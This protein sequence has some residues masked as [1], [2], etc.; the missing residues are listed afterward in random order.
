LVLL[1]ILFFLIV[2]NIKDI[3]DFKYVFNKFL[4]EHY[5]YD[6][7]YKKFKIIKGIRVEKMKKNY[8]HLFYKNGYYTQKEI[9][10]NYFGFEY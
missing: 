3:R 5:Y 4:F 2:K 9:L 7:Y 8:R 6:F 10:K 1:L